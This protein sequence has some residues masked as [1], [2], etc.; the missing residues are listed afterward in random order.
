MPVLAIGGGSGE[1]TSS[2]LSQV[3]D[4]LKGVV[5]DGV[6]HYVAMEA[7]ERLADELVSFYAETEKS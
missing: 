1:F 5:I 2:T 3:A 7:P 6:G 4:N